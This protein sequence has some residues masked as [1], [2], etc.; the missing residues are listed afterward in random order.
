[1]AGIA[2]YGL[3]V[4]GAALG[5]GIG[6]L[7]AKNRF[8]GDIV[9]AEAQVAAVQQ[10]K[11]SMLAEMESVASTVA[12]QNSEDFLRLAEE[13]LSKVHSEA[14]KD[15]DL[16]KKEVDSL[17][18]P[19]KDELK[20]LELA[21]IAMEKNREGAYQGLKRTVEGLEQQTTNLR[22]T[23]V[24]LSTALRG[25]I[26]ARGAWGQV[27]LKN[28]AE[29][30]GML[31][32]CDFDIEVTLKSGAGGGRVDLL[33]KIPDGGHIPVDSKVPLAAYWDGLD[34]ED[35]DARALKMKEHAKSVKK[36]IDDLAERDYPRM[37]E[38][39]DFTVMF[40]PAEPILSTAF[41]YEPSL[42]EYAFGKH[43]LIV[44]P[45]TL[46]ALLRTVG[47][48]W[49]QQ[50]M[51]Q[52]AKEIHAHA[53]EFYGRAAKFSHDLA[54][55]GKNLNTVVGAYND[56][57]A[58]YDARLVPS[59]KKLETLKVTEGTQKKL[60]E[61]PQISTAVRGVKHLPLKQEE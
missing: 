1:M 48:Y 53:R 56:A 11:Q 34:H 35:G 28:I 43:V 49:Q 31:E 6:W 24:K 33:A 47:L 15:Y 25:S 42:Q 44:T 30:A 36:H 45:V 13:R 37:L 18:T 22:D 55:M 8:T 39:T 9:R 3:M 61:L 4:L 10:S 27:A 32:H 51:A 26:K 41:E 58:S 23:S 12:R 57:V 7:M 46:I 40:I 19:I 20:K 54:K 60:A 38:G 59:G 50:S 52:N 14:E 5:I 2:E 16:R 17:V 21:T 29:A